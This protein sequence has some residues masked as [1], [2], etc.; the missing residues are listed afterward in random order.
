MHNL[1]EIPASLKFAGIRHGRNFLERRTGL[2]CPGC[3]C[4][5]S[6]V[7]VIYL[8]LEILRRVAYEKSSIL[9]FFSYFEKGVAHEKSSILTVF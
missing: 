6:F 1:I 5:K 7:S 2:T 9:T 4:A 8:F 3:T